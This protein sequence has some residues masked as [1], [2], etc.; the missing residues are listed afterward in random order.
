[1]TKLG[2]GGRRLWIFAI[3]IFLLGAEVETA[4]AAVDEPL[5]APT[6]LSAAAKR[7]VG[8][9]LSWTAPEGAGD[10]IVGYRVQRREDEAGGEFQTVANTQDTGTAYADGDVRAGAT[11]RYRVRALDGRQVSKASNVAKATALANEPPAFAEGASTARSVA[12]NAAAGTE[13][14]GPVGAADPE[15]DTLAYALGGEDGDS[16]DI[17]ESSG[18]LKTRGGIDYDHESKNAYSVTVMADDGEGG[19]ASIEV[20]VSIADVDEPPAFAEGPST[21]RSV[22]ENAAAGTEV[23]APVGA[24]DPE[25]DALAYALDGG[26]KDSFDIDGA[27]GQLRTRGGIDYDHEVKN[28]YSVTVMADDGEGGT[29]SIEVAVSVA[30]VNEPLGAPTD[31]AATAQRGVGIELS[32]GAPE[33]AG[34][35]IVGYRVQ[36][37]RD[38]GDDKFRAIANTEAAATAYADADVRP[39]VTY[40]YRVRALDRRQA[41]KASNAAKATAVG[42]EPPAFGEGGSTTRSLAE[43]AAAGMDVGAPV[44]AVDPEGDALAYALDGGDKDSFDID[45]A[46]GQLRTRGGI[47]Y[48]Y[49]VKNAYSV[50]VTA[51]DEFDASADIDVRIDLSDFKE[52]VANAGWD[53]TVPA[54][55]TVHLDGSGSTGE[56]AP[57]WSWSLLSWPGDRAP[58]LDDASDPTPS[59]VAPQEGAYL[60]ELAF[61]SGSETSTDRVGVTAV[62]PEN[63]DALL[64]ADL[65]VDVDR[66]GELTRGDERGEDEDAWNGQTGAV[67]GPNLDDDDDDGKQDAMDDRVN[68]EADLEDMAPVRV[69]RI[70]GLNR[71]HSA[72]LELSYA[73]SSITPRLFLRHPE[74]GFEMLIGPDKHSAALPPDRLVAGDLDLHLD[75]ALGRDAGFDGRLSLTLTVRDEAGDAEVSADEVALRG[76]PILFSHR[77]QSAEG[78]FF[79]NTGS[80]Q[81]LRNALDLRLPESVRKHE[82]PRRPY[83]W[84]RWAQD[85]MQTGYFQR[86]TG[87]GVETVP[88]HVRLHRPGWELEDFLPNDYLGPDRAYVALG[89]NFRSSR[90]YG[91][92]LEVVPP[93]THAGR[94]Y[95]YGRVVI[96]GWP[97][98]NKGTMVRRQIDFFNAQAVQGPPIQVHSS[99]LRVGHVDEIVNFVP[100]LEAGPE[101]RGWMAMIASSDLAIEV[102]RAA[103][104][105]GYGDVPVLEGR[106][107][108]TTVSEILADADLL[109]K[110]DTAQSR[111]DSVRETLQAEVGLTDAEFVEVPILFRRQSDG[112]I[113]YFPSVQNLLAVDG[114]LIVPDPEGPDV[115]GVDILQQATRD[116]LKDLGYDI[117]FVD[118]YKYHKLSGAIHC[119]TNVEH[120][121][122]TK[123][124]W[125]VEASGEGS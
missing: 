98:P 40:R 104:D 58:V 119:G 100:N 121:G 31:M 120:R 85:F 51:S 73:S 111:L 68:G 110:N 32:W 1:M 28:A 75:S 61:V 70:R 77:L 39:G 89:G 117:H 76:S 123:P 9:E 115:D 11:Y 19:T 7:G 122:E 57:T 86:P 34:N 93:H 6:N 92:N 47:D 116:A 72:E 63:A 106:G 23:G 105:N 45:G 124:W 60:V 94:S 12:E 64:T 118:V 15:G 84:D 50:T 97:T 91:G 125:L 69:R 108:E 27:S 87:A 18:Q 107:A 53:L 82:I 52:S 62:P 55:G 54:G 43:N 67:F 81:A 22:T 4:V 99:W 21:T 112:L 25:G 3:F 14:G 44:S 56:R 2:Q 71:K 41:S 30:D 78:V 102:L 37:R 49:E 90:N 95:P 16:F 24:V 59:F 103:E 38:E 46:S 113:S 109:Q 8:I 65:L 96:G 101:D 29:A 20:A 13:V 5:G 79:V 35:G 74:G 36:R 17:N 114:V 26:D 80:N 10:G 66:D 42:N 33:E 83:G 48:D 88:V